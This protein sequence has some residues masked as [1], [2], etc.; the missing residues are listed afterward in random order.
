MNAPRRATAGG[1]TRTPPRR[2]RRRNSARTW[3]APCRRTKRH[4]R[5]GQSDP[6][7]VGEPE[8]QQHRLLDPLMR[9]PRRRSFSGDAQAPGVEVRDHA[10][11]RRIAD[12]GG[13]SAGDSA[14]A[15]FPRGVD[16]RL[17]VRRKC[18]YGRRKRVI[19]TAGR[20]IPRASAGGQSPERRDYIA[21]NRCAK[22]RLTASFSSRPLSTM[23]GSPR[24][25]R[26][27]R[28]IARRLTIVPR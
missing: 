15:L 24:Q 22:V 9:D 8:R 28:A 17:Q 6:R 7:V 25:S 21:L 20:G 2:S 13:A 26:S 11:G 27:T 10:R 3:S 12:F 18:A 16:R 23:T 4:V 1:T 19:L 14:C 5:T